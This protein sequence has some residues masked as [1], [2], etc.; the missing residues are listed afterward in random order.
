MARIFRRRGPDGKWLK[1][2]YAWVPDI[3]TGGT[4]KVSTKCTDPA[5]AQKRADELE[6]DAVDPDSA[7]AAKATIREAIGLLLKDRRSEVTGGNMSMHT[8]DFYQKKG[9]VLLDA[10]PDVLGRPKDAPVYLREVKASLVDD[11]VSQRRDD[12]AGENTISKE[13]TTWRAAMR[14]AKRRRLWR[15]DIDECF[16]KGFSSKYEP[17][18]RWLTPAELITLFRALVRVIP[19]RKPTLT[20]ERI[21]AMTALRGAGKSSRELAELF[22]VSIPTVNRLTSPSRVEP[23]P[24]P[25]QGHDL[26]A[27]IAFAIAT[28]SEPSAIWRARRKDVAEDYSSA[29]V[30]GSKNS[31]RKNRHVTL[32]LLAFRWLLA[33]ALEHAAGDAILFPKSQEANLRRMLGEAC[34]RAGIEPVCLTDLR[35]THGKWLRLSGV[36]PSNIGVNLG[37]ADGR[38]AERVY[39]KV[40]AEE[41]ARV[42]EAQ[43]SLTGGSGLL[44]GM[45]PGVTGT[46]RTDESLIQPAKHAGNHE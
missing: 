3:D 46:N 6:R 13:L 31:Y 34:K 17:G 26:F 2:W 18:E 16:P 1:T 24:G 9:G 27:I 12:G 40:S 38:M 21:A 32:P 22:D 41:L 29:I 30:R 42:L 39:G 7:A 5:A 36:S 19:I 45:G 14:I 28:G 23:I 37:H 4:R 35:R 8:V 10:L 20:P 25:E 44:M 11:Y 15:G 33:Y 43:V